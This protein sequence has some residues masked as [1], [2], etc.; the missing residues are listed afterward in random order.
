MTSA[1]SLPSSLSSSSCSS[2]SCSS[3]SN[4]LPPEALQDTASFLRQFALPPTE[5]NT[6]GSLVR[7][8]FVLWLIRLWNQE[9]HGSSAFT[10][11][12]W[13]LAMHEVLHAV[14]KQAIVASPPDTSKQLTHEDLYEPT[15]FGADVRTIMRQNAE[16][17]RRKAVM[18]SQQLQLRQ[19]QL[20][21][22]QPSI[23]PPSS[24]GK[25]RKRTDTVTTGSSSAGSDGPPP[26][27]LA[28]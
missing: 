19:Q 23:D 20:Q 27:R 18:A 11:S 5:C 21:L 26:K 3:T 8:C 12:P 14:G 1:N 16:A 28:P 6:D 17:A 9:A 22:L 25:K 15:F 13:T 2:S 4:P 24:V 7:R 10:R